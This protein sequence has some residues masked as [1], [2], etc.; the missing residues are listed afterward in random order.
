MVQSRRQVTQR[1][2]DAPPRL[3]RRHE[4][5]QGR[6]YQ[7]LGGER[8]ALLPRVPVAGRVG[9]AA[10][11]SS[12]Q[13]PWIYR[14]TMARILVAMGGDITSAAGIPGAMQCDSTCGMKY[15]S[16]VCG[17]HRTAAAHTSGHSELHKRS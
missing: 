2:R 5:R 17:I 9:A 14:I 7:G 1:D 13:R 4:R 10:R 8:D 11:M 6:R 16:Q 12:L 15:T 3:P